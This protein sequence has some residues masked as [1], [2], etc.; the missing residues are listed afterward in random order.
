MRTARTLSA[1]CLAM[2][3]PAVACA[4]TI[5]VD[6]DAPGFQNGTSWMNAFVYLQ[7]AL[8]SA[9]TGDT[10]RVAE[11]VYR[12][13][14]ATG[15]VITDRTAT[16][17]LK[18]GVGLYG[19]YAGYGQPSPNDRNVALYK[20]VLSGDLDGNDLIVQITDPNLVYDLLSSPTR[21]ENAY[22]VVTGTGAGSS[23]ILD[24]FTIRGGNAN[25]PSTFPYMHER[26]GGL[27][28]YGGPPA[29][30]GSPTIRNCTFTANSAA[31]YGGALSNHQGSSQI[32]NCK[33]LGNYSG[34]GGGGGVANWSADVTLEDCTFTWNCVYF[35][36]YGGAVYNGDSEA[37]LDGC[38]FTDNSGG[39]G[40]GAVMNYDASD[41]ELTDCYFADNTAQVG[42][43]VANFQASSPTM[44]R[45]TFV[46]NSVLESGGAV[47]NYYDCD[48]M[49]VGCSFVANTSSGDGGAISNWH[50]QTDIS[51]VNCLFNGNTAWQ[52]GGA[53]GYYDAS[54]RLLNCTFSANSAPLGKGRAVACEPVGPLYGS[55]VTIANSILWD[56]GDEISIDPDSLVTMNYSDMQGIWPYPSIGNLYANPQFMSPVGADLVAGNEDDDL[57][58]Q[59]GSPCI[60]A[61]YN[62]AVPLG[63]T[64][65]L[66]GGPRFVDDAATP[67]TG[68]GIPPIVDMG[69]YE[70]PTGAPGPGPGNDPPVANAG[71]DQ[72][73]FTGGL[74]SF[75]TLDG[76]GSYDLDGDPLYY[77]WT[78][79]VGSTPYYATGV[80]P[81]VQL[82]LGSHTITLVVFDGTDYSAPDTVTIQVFQSAPPPTA[83]VMVYPYLLS[84]TTGS[85][86]IYAIVRLVGISSGQVNLGIPLTI[87]PGGAQ[88]FSQYASEQ[89]TPTLMT[90]VIAFF[91]KADVT[92]AIPTNGLTQ[93]T[94]TGW[95][96]S[97]VPFSGTDMIWVSP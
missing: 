55:Q 84:R 2:A 57:R 90:T 48:P 6:A 63:I 51:I 96:Q 5:Y 94:V 27:F 60:D 16:F 47:H 14:Q 1:W 41:A 15:P 28:S 58:L 62:A 88:A 31:D 8:A 32:E 87:T 33:F 40:G 37:V 72:T 13:N 95:L 77:H 79:M 44:S 69:A 46:R 91:H 22:N 3:V 78:W 25:G 39:M 71:A 7:D 85:Q 19:G 9:T 82:P 83:D 54:G 70:Y 64:V 67:D 21:Q 74:F 17:Q 34:G 86:Y 53:V 29:S 11:G 36:E 73:V 61:A 89:T 75:V 4:A 59:S 26:G 10:I 81:T 42:G 38:T 92:A 20:T 45:C 23:A 56:G 80:S 30:K 93:L 65:D 97:S 52:T 12:P 35:Q 66:N 43:A 18:T 24:G 49:I 68:S 50:C 76:S